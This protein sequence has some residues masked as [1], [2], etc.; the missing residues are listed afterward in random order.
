[1]VGFYFFLIQ[2]FFLPISLADSF[3][4]ELDYV[5][6]F[7]YIQHADHP[8]RISFEVTNNTEATKYIDFD[9]TVQMSQLLFNDQ[10]RP[11]LNIKSKQP[12]E[13]RPQQKYNWDLYYLL[14]QTFLANVLIIKHPTD[15]EKYNVPSKQITIIRDTNEDP[16]WKEQDDV[17]YIFSP[18]GYLLWNGVNRPQKITWKYNILGI[19]TKTHFEGCLI[20]QF[21]KSSCHRL[22]RPSNDFQLTDGNVRY[23]ENPALII[24]QRSKISLLVFSS[25]IPY[26][27]PM[28]SYIPKQTR[29]LEN[30]DN[31]FWL[32]YSEDGLDILRPSRTKDPKLP[33]D[34]NRI[35]KKHILYADFALQD[36]LLIEVVYIENETLK[37]QTMTLHGKTT[38]DQELMD[39]T[40]IPTDTTISKKDVKE[41]VVTFQNKITRLKIP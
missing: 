9:T 4:Q 31:L 33:M 41:V 32:L 21:L 14:P 30:Q 24:Q 27:V 1:M 6:E 26:F 2:Y 19:Q 29:S 13:L 8:I 15:N 18:Q 3:P 36:K 20:D 10:K 12:I 34:G 5:I 11:P 7:P 17:Y 22:S 16:Y 40:T 25:P 37:Y 38:F 23:D 39:I 35:L 28:A